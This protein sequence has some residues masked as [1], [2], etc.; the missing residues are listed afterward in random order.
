MNVP[1]LLAAEVL[2][3]GSPVSIT[4]AVL[5][6]GSVVTLAVG[7]AETRFKTGAQDKRIG[8]LEEAVQKAEEKAARAL[9]D[10]KRDSERDRNE[11][12]AKVQVM[13]V[14]AA[15]TK[16]LMSEVRN[17]LTQHGEQNREQLRML[18]DL[19]GMLSHN[20]RKSQGEAA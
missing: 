7:L 13:E 16:V 12:R 14:G 1:I 9:D 4:L 11:I 15:E 8:A 19:M 2:S 17:Q 20:R 10:A 5:V 3:E 6:G 18:H